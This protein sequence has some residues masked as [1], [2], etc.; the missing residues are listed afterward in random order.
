MKISYTHVRQ[1]NQTPT[2]I[3]TWA[4]TNPERANVVKWPSYRPFSSKCPMLICTEAWSLAVMI[5]F[6]AELQEQNENIAQQSHNTQPHRRKHQSI[7]ITCKLGAALTTSWGHKGPPPYPP[8]SPW[9]RLGELPRQRLRVQN[10]TIRVIHSSFATSI[11]QFSM[12]RE[13]IVTL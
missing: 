13:N 5:L 7:Q 2:R 11:H 9:W 6:V 8:R 10:Q 12:K 1:S 3:I 4:R